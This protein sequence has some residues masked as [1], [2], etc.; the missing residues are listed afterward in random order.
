MASL[1]GAIPR[2]QQHCQGAQDQTSLPEG[3]HQRRTCFDLGI[4]RIYQRLPDPWTTHT[5]R[6]LARKIDATTLSRFDVDLF[7]R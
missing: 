2:A 7:M 3:T 1:A 4:T 6:M 5:K